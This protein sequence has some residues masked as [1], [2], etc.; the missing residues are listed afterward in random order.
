MECLIVPA[1]IVKTQNELDRML[2]AVQKKVKRVQLDVM[3]GVFVSNTSLNF[4]F[5]LP[6]GLEY[7]A[8]LMVQKPLEWVEKYAEKVDLVIMHV[9]TLRDLK[10]AIDYVKKKG[11][12]VGIALK[13][14]TKIE[15]ILPY[16][17][18]LDSVLIMTVEPGSYCIN[19]DFNLE[20]LGKIKK[21]R[22]LDIEISIEVDGCMNPENA[23]LAREYGANIFASGSYIFKSENID[24]AIKD[25]EQAVD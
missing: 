8:H 9:E 17:K 16:L 4:D 10:K 3:D 20:N 25:L 1:I 21:I 19:K 13:P 22:E 14:E 24:N 18:D 5:R 23:Q 2:S 11:V 7:E 15:T 12:Q 6:S